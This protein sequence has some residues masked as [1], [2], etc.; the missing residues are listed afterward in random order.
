MPVEG[1][2]DLNTGYRYVLLCSIAFCRMAVTFSPPH[3]SAIPHPVIHTAGRRLSL[4]FNSETVQSAM[5]LDDPTRLE[6]EYTRAMMLFLLFN[7]APRSILMIGLGGGSLPK[8][9]H[10]HLPDCDI[11]VVEINPAVIALREVFQ[12]PPDGPRF[13]VLEG[14]GAKHIRETS[15]LHDVILVDGFSPNG[16]PEALATQDF[17][18]SCRAALQVDGVLVVNLDSDPDANEPLLARLERTFEGG[19]KTL[20]SDGGTNRIVLAAAHR[21]LWETLRHARRRLQGLPAVHRE[22]LGRLPGAT[23]G[24]PVLG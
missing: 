14:D 21:I 23:G 13:H 1:S 3:E 6:L 15:A 11:T 9:C 5:N 4:R 22:T 24:W 10:R 18:D 19:V 2:S 12:V 8:Y 7:P 16:Q 17:Y 20:L